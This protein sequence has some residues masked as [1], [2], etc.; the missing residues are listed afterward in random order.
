MEGGF[1]CVEGGFT[2]TEGGFTCAEGGFTSTKG[3]FTGAEGRFI[4]AE[5][6]F[7]CRASRPAAPSWHSRAPSTRFSLATLA[8][9]RPRSGPITS[10]SQSATSSGDGA[11]GPS[12]LIGP[13]QGADSGAQQVDSGA[14]Q[15]DSGARQVNSPDC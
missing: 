11:P 8:A 14:Q 12:A 7:T 9:S 4:G 1:T 10:S 6:G 3:G 13:T 15:V 2:G 5:G